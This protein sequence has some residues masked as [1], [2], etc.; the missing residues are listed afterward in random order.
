MINWMYF[1]KNKQLD[2]ISDQVVR[3]FE[4]VATAIDSYSHHL[5]SDEV[6]K[7]V[8]PG[9]E[10]LGFDVEKSKKNDDIITVPVLYGVNGRIEKSF[11]A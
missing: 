5:K 8:R 6:L 11:E 4:D 3:A 9:L 10:A 2:T 7:V 1:P